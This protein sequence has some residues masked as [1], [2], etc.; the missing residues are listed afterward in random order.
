MAVAARV[1]A[2]LFGH[3][4]ITSDYTNVGTL[5]P[6]YHN[7]TDSLRIMDAL[8]HKAIRLVGLSMGGAVATI[9][10]SRANHE[11]AALDLVASAGFIDLDEMSNYDIANAIAEEAHD[12]VAMCLKQPLRS[13]MIAL[14]SLRNCLAR[15]HAVRAEF[16]AL[17]QTTVYDDLQLFRDNQPEASVTLAHGSHDK[18]VPRE[19]LLG[20]IASRAAE[21]LFTHMLPYDGSHIRLAYD[22]QLAMRVLSQ[23]IRSPFDE[24]MQGMYAQAA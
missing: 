4:A 21:H 19:R 17:M 23:V 2:R 3:L 14:H 12:E 15:P 9:A 7:A 24:D 10:A 18:L 13:H 11:I 16:E 20:S 6:L 5:N 22:E 1:D 8:P